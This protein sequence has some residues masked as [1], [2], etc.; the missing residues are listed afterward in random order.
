MC[1][2]IVTDVLIYR[3]AKVIIYLG[4]AFIVTI[5]DIFKLIIDNQVDIIFDHRPLSESGEWKYV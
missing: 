5:F 1:R 4:F 2:S 3:F